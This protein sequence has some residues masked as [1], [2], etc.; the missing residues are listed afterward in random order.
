S[1]KLCIHRIPACTPQPH[2]QAARGA[3]VGQAPSC[4]TV[5]RGEC[6]VSALPP[7]AF[8]Y[9]RA[10]P[11]NPS[12]RCSLMLDMMTMT[13]IRDAP[14]SCQVSSTISEIM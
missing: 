8:G 2:R 5:P 4:C 6:N 1:R 7:G 13:N 10:F 3:L 9:R 12:Q 11:G 14:F